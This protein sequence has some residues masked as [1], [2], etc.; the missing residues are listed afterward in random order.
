M[1][2]WRAVVAVFAYRP[3]LIFLNFVAVT[4]VFVGVQLPAL[5]RREYFDLLTGEPVAVGLL[6]VLTMLGG[7]GLA[8]VLGFY[9]ATRTNVPIHNEVGA[10]LQKN[11]LAHILSRPGDSALPASPGEAISRFRSDVNSLHGYPIVLANLYRGV[12]STA[13]ALAIMTSIDGRIAFLACLPFVAVYAMT[14]LARRRIEIYRKASRETEGGVTGFI[15]EVF[16]SV[17]SIKTANA[18]ER[19][20]NHF[21][22]LNEHRGRTALRDN[23]FEALLQSLIL[24]AVHLSTGVILIAAASQIRA[25]QFTV[26]ELALFT[27]YMGVVA[28]GVLWNIS[29]SIT[30]YRQAGVS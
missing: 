2:T 27:Y 30:R 10:L 7:S 18:E 5:A 20:A 4:I 6:G 13:V 17:Q 9:L 26:G 23:L 22:G 28:G 19:V 1:K 16:G 12:L 15:G 3:L 24:N 14:Q 25:G 11:M 29:L 21:C 8:F